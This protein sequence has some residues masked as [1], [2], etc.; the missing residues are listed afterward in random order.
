MLVQG[1]SHHMNPLSLSKTKMYISCFFVT[2]NSTRL[3]HRALASIDVFIFFPFIGVC[4]DTNVI[5][6]SVLEKKTY[7]HVHRKRRNVMT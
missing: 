6:Q 2:E 5:Y 4:T 3:Q 7:E 1:P